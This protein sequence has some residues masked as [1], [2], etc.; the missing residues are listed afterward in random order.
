VRKLVFFSVILLA[1]RLGDLYTTWLATPDLQ[2]EWSPLV[3]VFGFGWKQLLVFHAGMYVL[4]VWLM[5]FYFLRR[6]NVE[7]RGLSFLEYWSLLYFRNKFEGLSM[8]RKIPRNGRI[9]LEE[10]GYLMAFTF[11][12]FS[13][14]AVA[15][16]VCFGFFPAYGEW[17]HRTLSP[18]ALP[19]VLAY[20]LGNIALF[21][22]Y[23]YSKYRR[24]SSSVHT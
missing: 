8:L 12:P 23:D 11:L 6:R 19:A 5:G 4:A 24:M 18:L 16:N 22:W 17:F 14:L 7:E 9:L 20:S 2:N 15:N 13:I 10:I 3:T 21:H 1:A